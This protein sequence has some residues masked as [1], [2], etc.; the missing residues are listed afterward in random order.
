MICTRISKL[1]ACARRPKTSLWTQPFV[2]ELEVIYIT[3]K[4]ISLL[5]LSFSILGQFSAF[6]WPQ[7]RKKRHNRDQPGE[8]S[9]RVHRIRFQLEI[10]SFASGVSRSS[11]FASL[12]LPP[13]L[14]L[15]SFRLSSVCF[16]LRQAVAVVAATAAVGYQTYSF[17]H[18]LL[19]QCSPLVRVEFR[20]A[21]AVFDGRSAREFA[22]T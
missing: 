2:E 1:R 16:L 22:P 12:S 8:I 3:L 13:S 11:E 6:P 19:V 10:S 20:L 17:V 15:S 9:A 7:P 21:P 18:F 5:L 14:A 4:Y